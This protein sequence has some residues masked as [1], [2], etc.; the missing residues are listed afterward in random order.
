MALFPTGDLESTTTDVWQVTFNDQS[1]LLEAFQG[2]LLL[3][4]S[5]ENWDQEGDVDPDT[6]ATMAFDLIN[7]LTQV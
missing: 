1:W 2:A 3:M 6:A 7:S 4:C 5:P